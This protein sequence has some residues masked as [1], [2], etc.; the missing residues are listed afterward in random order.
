MEKKPKNNIDTK[1]GP[2][3]RKEIMANQELIANPVSFQI[4]RTMAEILTERA[5]ENK[6]MMIV[7]VFIP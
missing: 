7:P 1:Y 3:F 5:A 6:Q 2:D 4:E